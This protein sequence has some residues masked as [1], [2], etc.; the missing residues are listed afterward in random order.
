MGFL[1]LRTEPSARA[2]G[3]G[4][5]RETASTNRISSLTPARAAREAPSAQAPDAT[6]SLLRELTDA[7]GVVGFEGSVRDILRRE[8]AGLLTEL[9]TDGLGNLLGT[10]AG[11]SDSPRVLLMA[12]MDEVGFLVRYIDDDGFIYFNNVGGYFAQS[13]LT[14]RLSILTP[15]GPVL[16][17]RE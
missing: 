6:V 1:C 3:E 10:L 17:I 11:S 5:V 13:V 14:Q 16:A 2:Q 15:N 4:P 7:H 9:R 8:W 12:H